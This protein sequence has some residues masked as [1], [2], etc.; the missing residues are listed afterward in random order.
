MLFEEAWLTDG[1]I[2]TAPHA[3]GSLSFLV[4]MSGL[5]RVTLTGLSGGDS[6]CEAYV[7]VSFIEESN[8]LHPSQLDLMLVSF[9]IVPISFLNIAYHLPVLI[10]HL[11]S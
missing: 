4:K 1:L 9:T 5:G 8:L 7:S 3:F 6:D 11:F 10:G 2:R